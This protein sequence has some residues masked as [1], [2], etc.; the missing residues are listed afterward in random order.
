MFGKPAPAFFDLPTGPEAAWKIPSPIP[1]RGTL[2]GMFAVPAVPRP[3]VLRLV[4]R[5]DNDF[6]AHTAFAFAAPPALLVR[7]SPRGFIVLRAKGIDR[8]EVRE[9]AFRA[10][11]L[12]LLWASVSQASSAPRLTPPGMKPRERR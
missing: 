10:G 5:T 4:C 9:P 6:R 2:A 11:V 1:A 12:R 8:A 7:V 3:R